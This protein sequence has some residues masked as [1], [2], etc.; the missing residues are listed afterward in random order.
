MFRAL[1]TSF[2]IEF[3]GTFDPSVLPAG[4]EGLDAR[5]FGVRTTNLD[6]L[7]PNQLYLSWNEG[8]KEYYDLATDPYQLQSLHA[9]PSAQTKMQSLDQ[10]LN[11]LKTCGGGTCQTLEDQ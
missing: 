4:L 11:Q 9:S 6:S 8:S 7:T 5:Y 3:L 10:R 2:L 1:L